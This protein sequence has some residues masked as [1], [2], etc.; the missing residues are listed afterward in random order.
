M[1]RIE[2]EQHHRHADAVVEVASRRHELP[3]KQALDQR[4]RGNPRR[5]FAGR[6]GDADQR[7]AALIAPARDVGA[8]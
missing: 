7:A 6:A 4:R 8:V 1:L 3:R 5:R 2:A